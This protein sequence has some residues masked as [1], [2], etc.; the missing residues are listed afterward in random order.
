VAAIA[1]GATGR[2]QGISTAASIPK[3][4]RAA[5]IERFGG[6]E[7]LRIH[8]LPV[9]QLSPQ[10]VLIEMDTG[11]V[12]SWDADMRQGWS[13]DGHP[14]LPLVPGTDGA[15]IVA[16]VGAR[17][18]R[19]RAG[20]AVY[21]YSFNNPK[22]GFYAEYVAVSAGKVG[23][24]P[25]NLDLLHAGAIPTT[26]LTALQGI[27]CLKLQPG[28]SVIIH[29]ASGGVGTLAVQLAKWRGARVFATA[30]GKDGVNTAR[31]LGADVAVDGKR[32]N[33]TT[34]A[35]RFAPDGADA[36]LGLVGGAALMQCLGAVRRGGRFAYPNGLEPEPARRHGVKSIAYDA[37]ASP[38]Q[39]ERLGIAVDE[40]EIAV[41]I[42]DAYPLELAAS[43]HERIARHHVGKVVLRMKGRPRK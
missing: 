28:M 13:P 9:P 12:G 37:V 22:G 10:E 6:P 38:R 7:V 32:V 4:M 43:A 33:V 31:A 16:A 35:R 29:G 5:V 27:D 1:P 26:G 11:G 25:E 8:E 17:V 20:D 24:V 19:F 39:F 3:S 2:N 23:F 36:M 34:H 15:G 42:A 41:V 21:A 14:R 40:A 18:K 30:T